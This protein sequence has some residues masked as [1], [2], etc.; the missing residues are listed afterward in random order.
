VAKPVFSGTWAAYDEMLSWNL[1]YAALFDFARTPQIDI[2]D[3][4]GLVRSRALIAAGGN[5]RL[6]LNGSLAPH[7]LANR[8]LDEFFGAGVQHIAFETS[9]LLGTVEDM[10][11][12]GL[13]FLDIPKNYY[14]DLAARYDLDPGFLDRLCCN[15]ILYDRDASGHFLQI[16][17]HTIA[18]RFFFEIVERHQYLGFG[19]ANASVRLAAQAREARPV[20]LPKR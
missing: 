13:T 4:G 17:T 10:R 8:L 19:A 15:G 6:T 18:E 9:D 5:C 16:Y 2:A 12:R 3:P 7:T 1:F 14:D 20:T 11:A